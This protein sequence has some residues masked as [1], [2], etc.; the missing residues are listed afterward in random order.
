MT[1][2]SRHIMIGA[3]AA[4]SM[5]AV[6]GVAA[7]GGGDSGGKRVRV[8]SHAPAPKAPRPN[9]QPRVIIPRVNV[10][11]PNVIVNQGDVRINQSFVNLSGSSA[12][13]GAFFGGGGGFATPSTPVASSSLNLL[14]VEGGEEIIVET[15]TKEIPVTTETCT[16]QI[17]Q[18]VVVRPVQAVCI[19]DSGTPH[20]ASR[21][22]A[23]EA[24]AEGYNGELFRCLAGTHM[25]VT[26]G[27]VEHGAASF[28][29]GE[30]FSCAKGEALVHRHG[31]QLTC[32]PATPQ[33]NCNER[34]L[35]RRNGVGIKLVRTI[36][37]QQACV[38]TQHTTY[39]TVTEQVE[40]R[41]QHE[42]T[43]IVLDGGVGQGVF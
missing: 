10:R 14:N 35:L 4:I 37:H 3:F 31:G 36:A 24:V 34:S 33:R 43:S 32:A 38:P 23:D 25:Q 30:T 5:V 27:S 20:P 11:V 13:A 19:D 29:H 16:A 7:A 40:R 8:P 17:S 42:A 9:F 28:A 6:G 1:V 21:L 41:V 15:I 39:R 2:S 22:T 18:A 12:S 26:L